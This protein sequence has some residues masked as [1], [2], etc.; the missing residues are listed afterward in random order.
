MS[1]FTLKS[2][3]GYNKVQFGLSQEEVKKIDGVAPKIVID[4]ILM[5]VY[6][7]RNASITLTFEDDRLVSVMIPQKPADNQVYMDGLMK[8][9]LFEPIMLEYLKSRYSFKE[10][11]RGD[12]IIFEELGIYIS[13]LGK[14]PKEGKVLIAFSKEKLS[15]YEL[16]I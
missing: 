13:G 11:K 14:K 16:F 1:V 2:Y 7:H 10:S 5:E 3:I 9:D 15:H 8:M 6:E 4:N 12:C